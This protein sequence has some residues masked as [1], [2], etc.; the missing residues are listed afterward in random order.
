MPRI[1]GMNRRPAMNAAAPHRLLNFAEVR[2][3]TTLDRRTVARLIESGGFP[4]PV[5]LSEGR[6]AFYEIEV[7]AFIASRP[8]D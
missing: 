1:S 6:V 4:A 3:R 8:R 2:A 5:R 7:D